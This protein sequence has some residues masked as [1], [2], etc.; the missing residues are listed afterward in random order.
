MSK[1]NLQKNLNSAVTEKDVENAY[2]EAFGK[3]YPNSITSPFGTDGLLA[4]KD[5]SSLLE[6]KHD[7][8]MKSPMHRSAVLVQAVFYLKR[9]ESK[10]EQ[11][12]QVVF[13]GDKNECFA[14]PSNTLTPYLGEKID[15]S[16]SPSGAAKENIDL[17]AK[18]AS[19]QAISPFIYNIDNNFDFLSVIEKMKKMTAN[20]PYAVTVSPNNLV[21][22]FSIFEKYVIVDH[23][24]SEKN[25]SKKNKD[26]SDEIKKKKAASDIVN[27]FFTCLT[28]PEEVFLHPNKKDVAVVRGREVKVR[29]DRFR[30]FF[31]SFKQKHSAS[32]IEVL[33]SFKDR[34]LEESFRRNTGAFFTP[35]LWAEEAHKMIAENL[36]ENW[37]DEYVVWDCSAGTAQLT[38][39]AR[40]K[41]LYISTLDQQDIDTI[42]DC[43]YSPEAVE[44]QY[45]FLDDDWADD[46]GDKIPSGL[47]AAFESGKKVLFLINPPYVTANDFGAK[48]THK[49]GIAKTKVNQA[50]LAAGIGS[51]AQQLYA[52][53]IYR[54][55]RISRVYGNEV[56]LGL[57]SPALLVTGSSFTNLRRVWYNSNRFV[58]GMTFKASH[59]ADVS[60]DWGILFSLWSAGE[61]VVQEDLHIKVK[62]VDDNLEVTTIGSKRLYCAD[63]RMASDWV[64]EPVKKFKGLD[65][66]QMTNAISWKDSK[67]R[68]TTIVDAIGYMAS[69]ANSIYDNSTT[70]FLLS[71][72]ASRGSGFSVS[73]SNF[74]RAIA[75]FTARKSMIGPY[76]N[77]INQKDEYIAPV[78]S[79]DGYV[80]WNDDCLVYALLNSAS[81]QSS[82]RQIDYDDKKWDIENRWFFM[83]N[84]EMK[85]LADQNNF[86]SMYQDAK[87]FSK[88][89]FVYERLQNMTLSDDAKA[90]LEAAR[91]LVRKSISVRKLYYDSNPQYHLDAWDAGWAQLKPMLKECFSDDFKKVTS[92]YKSF[93]DR[94]R[95]GVYEF[96]FLRK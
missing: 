22:V 55:H 66:P 53:F 21:K 23:Y 9:L 96:G 2:R 28:N 15:W 69:N 11:F 38:R 42:N 3:V 49:G 41:E 76:R 50:M 18:I 39:S 44:F 51:C 68:G 30:Q 91:E 59:F 34:I 95:E 61:T 94:M 64:R 8:D 82:L 84:E 54:I 63:G 31:Q 13:I 79:K 78:E 12:P 7:I 65:A 17:V 93:E 85:N 71:S 72:C 60:G 74:E 6:F 16:C 87:R 26:K 43:G 40:F 5:I 52:Q 46:L 56:S 35:D 14:L 88:D 27:L 10:G 32:E 29:A 86:S 58:D 67:N 37:K 33:T 70:V 92:L 75:L 77:W 1:N 90:I 20:L 48:G 36:G 25:E 62:D 47:K 83:S 80:Q 89:R 81:Q 19:D 57:F 4:H 73:E 45:D 24:K